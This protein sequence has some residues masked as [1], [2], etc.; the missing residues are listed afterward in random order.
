MIS[1]VKHPLGASIVQTGRMLTNRIN[2]HFLA[3]GTNI[4]FEQMEVL[5]LIAVHPE[6]KIIQ[7]DLAVTIQKNKSG[8]LRTIDILEKKHFV[9]RI[10]VKGDRRKNMIEATEEGIKIA[11]AAIE[12]FLKIDRELTKKINKSDVVT[13]NK[14]LDIIKKEC[15]PNKDVALQ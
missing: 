8:I 14:V 11:K 6:K 10:P 2:S 7:N 3:L 9:R 5:L 15:Q 1:K 13:S 12:L 4:T